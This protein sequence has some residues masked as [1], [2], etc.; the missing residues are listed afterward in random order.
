[1]QQTIWC[2]QPGPQTALLQCPVLDVFYGGARGGGKTDGLLGDFLKHAGLYGPKAKGILFRRS[3]PEL[4][5]VIAR[6]KELY[7]PLGWRYHETNHMWTAPNAATLKL[8]YLEKD[9]DAETYQ[10]QSHSWQGFDEIGNF[11]DP[12]P[13]DKLW[14]TLRSAQGVPRYRRSTGNPGGPGHAWVKKR[15]IVHGAW[16]VWEWAPL[17]ERPDLKIQST[18]IPSTL[19]DNPL[20]TQNDPGYEAA[21]AAV[22]GNVLFKAWRHGD[23]DLTAGQYF[24]LWEPSLHVVKRSA[25]EIQPW[26]VRWI[27]MDWGFSDSTAIHWHAMDENR[28]IWTY[29][30]LVFDGVTPDKTAD[31]IIEANRGEKIAAFFL[32][33]DAF[34]KHRSPRTI[35]AELRDAFRAYVPKKDE[36]KPRIAIPVKADDDRKGGWMLMYQLLQAGI[37][38]ITD[39]CEVLIEAIPLLQR[40]EKDPEDIV[41]MRGN[42]PGDHAPD[43]TRYGLK[44]YLR[45]ARVP[46]EQEIE[47][48]V[49]STD[50]TIAMI[51]R[52]IA[53]A[54]VR[55]ERRRPFRQRRKVA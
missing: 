48:R 8:A 4:E 13:I 54:K 38:K 52:S 34:G 50:P 27:S 39:N 15:Y 7:R 33:P 26:W 17:E 29:R 2:P 47:K 12:K 14:G 32:S 6:S 31:A 36:E 3:Y 44:S 25:L 30:E 11:P 24:D 41:K 22:G 49:T 19:D 28:H 20:L 42:S 51:Q 43:S 35:A 21:L 10:G 40:D 46:I 37:W 5:Q 16:N 18:F 1:M 55:A 23:W 45:G 53:E 9:S